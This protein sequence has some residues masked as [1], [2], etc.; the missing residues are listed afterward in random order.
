MGAEKGSKRSGGFF[1]L[2]DRNRKSRKK[3]FA[4]ENIS[5]EGTKQVKRI[6]DNQQNTRLNLIDDEDIVGVSTV[7]GGSSYSSAS[8]VTDDGVNGIRAPGLVA[9]LMGLD[10]L[11]TSS[12][13]ESFSMPLL[14]KWQFQDKLCN[15]RSHVSYTDNEFGFANHRIDSNKKMPSSPIE[16]FQR[17]MM[18]TTS[19]LARSLP[20]TQ[21]KLLSP[22]KKPGFISAPSAVQ[23]MEAAAKILEPKLQQTFGSS[24]TSL[25]VCESRESVTTYQKASKIAESSSKRYMESTAARTLRG[26]PLSKS[27]NGSEWNANS[28]RPSLDLEKNNSDKTTGKGKSISLAIQAKVNVQKRENLGAYTRSIPAEENA[29]SKMNQPFQKHKQANKSSAIHTTGVLKQNNQKQN[30]PV[31]REKSAQKASISNQRRRK[32]VHTETS[33]GK[34]KTVNKLSVNQKNCL[35]KEV[36]DNKNLS[37]KKRLIGFS[38]Q[39]KPAQANVLIDEQ[40]RQ[41]EDGGNSPDVVSFTFTSPLIKDSND[42][43]VF[44]RD[45]LCETSQGLSVDALSVLLEQ[46]LRELT[47]DIGSPPALQESMVAS[48]DVTSIDGQVTGTEESLTEVQGPLNSKLEHSHQQPSPLS[49]LE[50]TFSNEICNSPESWDESRMCSSSVQAQNVAGSN[51]CSRNSTAAEEEKELT[52]S[53]SSRE[54]TSKFDSFGL[55]L[56]PNFLKNLESEDGEEIMDCET[57]RKLLSDCVNECLEVKYNKYFRAGYKNWAKGSSLIG[58]EMTEELY[59][60]ISGWKS[61]GE[62]MVDE[63]VDRD[64]SNNQGKWTDFEIEVFEEGIDIQRDI[65]TSLIDELVH[66]L[67]SKR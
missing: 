2:F 10:P 37:Q 43:N 45:T 42:R 55:S 36:L 34:N 5:P 1:H 39:E 24:S 52:D 64:M 41:K 51:N 14:D 61:M 59:R 20:I 8:S 62:C 6:H 53:A 32:A 44:R 4:N 15:K 31:S 40:L 66:D 38:K 30:C 50:V 3:L 67:G 9:R 65:L 63:L 33:S 7:I 22:I 29:Q 54:H 35:R 26:Q 16:R 18:P 57:R 49:V 48:L 58:K 13:S 19:R 56:D 46:K 11:P 17:E 28:S 23:I 60:E 12:V 21:H 27:W 25:K 47:S